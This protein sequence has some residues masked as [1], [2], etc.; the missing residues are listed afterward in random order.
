R[1]F[2]MSRTMSFLRSNDLIYTPAIR[3]YMMGETPPAFDLLFW[4]GDG[5]G[6]PGRMTTQYL[7]ELCQANAFVSDGIEICGERLHIRDVTVPIMAVTCETDHIAA[8]KDCYTGFL[9]TGSTDR[10]FIVSESGHI[11][12]IV[13]PPSKKKY[14][15][16]ENADLPPTAEAW[17][18]GAT[19]HEGSWWPAWEKWLRK[20]SGRKIPAREPGDSEHPT[21]APAPGTYVRKKATI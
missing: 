6:L 13:N 19:E 7:R 8:W 16:Y 14:G 21:L 11:A 17:L 18:A 9:Q 20:R 15:Y 5:A 12:G 4:N 3:T 1:S 2:I 10:T